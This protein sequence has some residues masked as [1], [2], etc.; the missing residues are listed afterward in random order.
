MRQTVHQM[1]PTS[2]TMACLAGVLVAAGLSKLLRP[3]PAGRALR[4]LGLPGKARVL[5]GGELVVAALALGAPPRLSAPVMAL[6]FAAF[7]V[8]AARLARAGA[9][10]GCFGVADERPPGRALV[11][12]DGVAALAAAGAAALGGAAPL[13]HGVWAAAAAAGGAIAVAMRGRRPAADPQRGIVNAS[14]AFLERRMSR[15]SALVRLAVAG[16]ALSVAPLRYLL[17]PEPALAVISPGSCGSG[18]CTDGYTAFCCEINNGLNQCPTG[19]FAG[20][21][22]MCTDYRGRRLCSEHGVRYYVDCN[23]IPGTSFPGGCH[24][25]NGTCS[26]RKVNCNVFRYGQCNTHVRGT[27]EVVCRM[28]TCT[29]PGLIPSLNCSRHVAVDNATCGHEAPCLSDAIQLAG[30]GGV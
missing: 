3:A 30:A 26:Q 23:R 11:A 4:T 28:I 27:T 15:R 7:A 17:Y 20:G 29:N 5:G 2:L 24:C 18:L 19:T 14:A 10:C 9:A 21:W 25:A 1:T 6:L 12:L 22:W 13:A 8:A 16:S